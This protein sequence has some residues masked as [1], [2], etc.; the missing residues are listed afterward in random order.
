MQISSPPQEL[1]PDLHDVFI[2]MMGNPEST[3]DNHRGSVGFVSD[4]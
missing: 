4:K 2:V 1:V 3:L